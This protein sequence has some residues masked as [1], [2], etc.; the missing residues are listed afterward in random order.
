MRCWRKF[1]A[2][3]KKEKRRK[4]IKMQDTKSSYKGMV[5][6]RRENKLFQEP[7]GHGGCSRYHFWYPQRSPKWPLPIAS[8][9]IVKSAWCVIFQGN[10]LMCR[11]PCK[12][13]TFRMLGVV[14][15]PSIISDI[16]GSNPWNSHRTLNSLGFPPTRIANLIIHRA[17]V[18][19]CRHALP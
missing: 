14:R 16:K 10:S 1:P 9:H 11:L 4:K 18:I 8:Q 17:P 13:S 12:E 3:G 19:V 6:G 5:F 15:R 2:E 7:P